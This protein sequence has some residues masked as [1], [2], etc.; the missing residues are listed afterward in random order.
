[1]PVGCFSAETWRQW[2]PRDD[3]C[4][5]LVPPALK[6]RVQLL[7]PPP[8]P[9]YFL[10]HSLLANVHICPQL[11]V[12]SAH[13]LCKKDTF[14]L[15][16]PYSKLYLVDEQSVQCEG[17]PLFSGTVSESN[18]SVVALDGPVSVYVQRKLVHVGPTAR[19]TV[20]TRTL[21]PEWSEEFYV[22]YHADKQ[23][24]VVIRLVSF[25]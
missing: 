7:T 15:S 18:G 2:Y 10:A 17:P 12:V 11:T 3:L 6:V 22:Q 9:F 4:R 16:D 23:Y 8:P 1:M 25:S 14:G 20:R 5:A 13:G 24:Y 19:T 21:N